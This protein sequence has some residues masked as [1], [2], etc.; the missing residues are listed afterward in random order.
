MFGN[1][2]KKAL[3]KLYSAVTGRRHDDDD[4]LSEKSKSGLDG[5]IGELRAATPATFDE[6]TE[7]ELEKR[8]A[9]VAPPQKHR[10]I[11]DLLDL[12]LVVGAVAF[13]IRALY[14][15]PFRIPTGSMQPTLYG[16][17][18]LDRAN[19]SNPLL[20]KLPPPLD[21]LLFAASRAKAQVAHDGMLAAE[22]LV[23][24]SGFTGD[25][26]AFRI[27]GMSYELPGDC[28]KVVDY[29]GL[30]PARSYKAGE[31]LADGFMGLG[32]HLFVERFSL[33]LTPLKR[34]EV[35]V[36][37]TDGLRAYDR[38][39]ADQSGTF[40]IKRVV[41]LPGDTLQITANQLWIKPRGEA[42]FHRL[43][44]L[45]P[46]AAKLYSNKGGYQGHL[47]GMGVHLFADNS[48]FTVPDDAYFVMGDNS[49]F[50]LDSRFFGAVPR[51]NFVGRAW[52]VFWPLSR[53]W[54]R[55]DRNDPVDAPTGEAA[56]YTYPVMNRQ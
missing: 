53:R 42:E 48:E 27:G 47:N 39:L 51:R 4:I 56:A 37:V 33:Y 10:K 32:D 12:L 34:G 43:Q 52:L 5:I 15:Q 36:F 35:A 41:G 19:A 54:G 44:E 29:A 3:K 23:Q 38:N 30:D 24:H 7:F 8:F 46:A 1:S 28:R 26:T 11:R 55:V 6:K 45:A 16:I 18:Y 25:S 14:F 20:G 31:M 49:R 13:G 50:S 21:F 22:S 9:A 2:R 40:Y 17:H